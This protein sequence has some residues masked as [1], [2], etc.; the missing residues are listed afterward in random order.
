MLSLRGIFKRGKTPHSSPSRVSATEDRKYTYTPLETPTSI[1]ILRLAPGQGNEPLRGEIVHT[2]LGRGCE[3]WDKDHHA[4]FRTDWNYRSYCNRQQSEEQIANIPGSFARKEILAYDE[5]NRVHHTIYADKIPPVGIDQKAVCNG[6]DSNIRGVRYKCL[7]CQDW[8]YCTPC[9]EDAKTTHPGHFLVPLREPLERICDDRDYFS[10]MCRIH[11][12]YWPHQNSDKN[13]SADCT[14]QG[15]TFM[16]PNAMYSDFRD[17]NT[18]AFYLWQLSMKHWQ[19]RTWIPY[20]AVSYAWGEV[21]YNHTLHTPHGLVRITES[22]SHAL[23]HLRRAEHHRNL[24][25][26]GIC[27]DQCNIQERGHQVKLMD[28]VYSSAEGVLVWLGTDPLQRAKRTFRVMSQV[29]TVRGYRG[30]PE[31]RRDRAKVE[32][33]TLELLK[34][35]WFTRVWVVQEF[36]LAR[37]AIFQWGTEQLDEVALYSCIQISRIPSRTW[38]NEVG[39]YSPDGAIQQGRFLDLMHIIGGLGCSNGHDH[40]Y[41]ILGLTHLLG[42]QYPTT[43]IMRQLTPNY[44]DLVEKTYFEVARLYV[45]SGEV[46]SLLSFVESFSAADNN[47]NSWV[48]DWRSPT[49]V[50]PLKYV[51]E[52][53]NCLRRSSTAAWL[54]R[55]TGMLSII[56]LE[57]DCIHLLTRPICDPDDILGN[58][59][60]VLELWLARPN[61]PLSLS[62]SCTLEPEEFESVLILLLGGKDQ[63]PT[64]S[65]DISRLEDRS[66][67]FLHNVANLDWETVEI[68]WDHIKED[69]K[70]VRMIE[71]LSRCEVTQNYQRLSNKIGRKCFRL[72]RRIFQTELGLLGIGPSGMRMGDRLVIVDGGCHPFPIIVRKV[73]DNHIFIGVAGIP[74][75][76]TANIGDWTAVW[77]DPLSRLN[78]IWRTK[79]HRVFKLR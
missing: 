29:E 18:D 60:A 8:D 4:I 57:L 14:D 56:G 2:D 53:G 65:R 6:C 15:I 25:I 40:V 38:M 48:P 69:R 26:D 68:I 78:D 70:V 59:Y 21:V 16:N 33:A 47:L 3:K 55:S 62:P 79:K 28:R 44:E 5:W 17:R 36:A 66:K 63:D 32:A 13:H 42:S 73:E 9:M 22:A 41:G 24:W 76:L 52:E 50:K 1:R 20:E 61:Q 23:L 51:W 39:I 54:D 27:I 31:Y 72:G 45:E 46:S 64:S 12:V 49:G 11:G 35:T 75:L 19:P 58:L 7:S 71:S 77:E 37:Q 30:T 43:K 34:K 67:G 74:A 10:D